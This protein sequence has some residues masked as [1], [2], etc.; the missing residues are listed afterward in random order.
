MMTIATAPLMTI[1][2]PITHALAR[3]SALYRE[4]LD[5]DDRMIRAIGAHLSEGRGKMFRPALTLLSWGIRGRGRTERA[6]WLA[7]AVEL[8]HVASL[9]HDDI[10]DGADLRRSRSTIHSEWGDEISV[11]VGDYL[12]AKGFQLLV[13]IG[14]PAILQRLSETTRLMCEG[15]L[16]EMGRRGD[17][18]LTERAY[19]EIITKKT[20]RLIADCCSLGAALGGSRPVEE[21]ALASYGMNL[22]MAFQIVDDCLDVSGSVR[23]LGKP[24][25]SDL[26]EG[27]V[28]L[29]LIH[30]TQRLTARQR[31]Q[32][33]R[34]LSNGHDRR[35]FEGL[36]EAIVGSAAVASARRAAWRY[37]ERAR[38][39]LVSVRSGPHK[40]GLLQL[41]DYVVQ[42]EH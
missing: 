42:R 28:T 22:G 21:R 15:E 16:L 39:A 25:G 29:P 6:V 4:Q 9:V 27:K 37:V 11:V 41:V 24:L 7:A 8:I 17:L 32:V 34:I 40:D 3:V 14:R 19:L 13:R 30:Y 36:R 5:S 33:V 10:V 1:Y 26:R 31:R 12:Y 38:R 20:A 18:D 2:G 23:S 35:L